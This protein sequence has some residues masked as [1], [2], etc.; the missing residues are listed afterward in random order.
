M[1]ELTVRVGNAWSRITGWP[2][3]ARQILDEAFSPYVPNAFWIQRNHDEK[4]VA[5]GISDPNCPICR[6]GWDCKKHFVTAKGGFPTGLLLEAGQVMASHGYLLRFIEEREKPQ[7]EPWNHSIT[8]YDDQG[9]IVERFLRLGQGC[10][11]M[12]TGGGKT[13][14]TMAAVCALGVPTLVVVPTRALVAKTLKDFRTHTE[15][16]TDQWQGAPPWP[17]HQ[18]SIT[19]LGLLAKHSRG[20]RKNTDAI[21]FLAIDEVHHTSAKS[22]YTNLMRIDAYYRLGQSA[23]AIG[24]GELSDV[25]LK[26]CTGSVIA[27]VSAAKLT[28][29]GRLAQ[30]EVRFLPVAYGARIS[31]HDHF[32]DL[33]REGIVHYAARNAYVRAVAHA[34]HDFGLQCLILCAWGEHVQAL[35]DLCRD[36]EHPNIEFLISKSSTDAKIR[37]VLGSEKAKGTFET[38][39]TRVLIA[40]PML[41][42]GIDIPDAAVL[43]PAG[44]QYKDRRIIQR[45][46][47]IRRAGTIGRALVFDFDDAHDD[48]LEDHSR[49]R[50]A[51]YED[52]A[53]QIVDGPLPQD[54]VRDVIEEYFADVVQLERS[55]QNEQ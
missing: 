47:R 37:K 28:S 29:E 17:T 51:T 18:V 6:S 55:E 15:A 13:Y 14:C 35:Y 38:G 5:K 10:Y 39:E 21:D 49:E 42:E 48:T 36:A 26:A 16:E 43:V 31:A 22:W 41:D 2:D 32:V 19:T 23:K 54:R 33:Y 9:E 11:E 44:A 24:D 25:Q 12:G 1:S 40:T 27:Q 52:Q 45:L 50:R 8:L 30:T 4:H 34:C 7:G 53:C 46:G 20:L 3:E